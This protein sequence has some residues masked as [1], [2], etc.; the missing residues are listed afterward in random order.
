MS[1]NKSP[2]ASTSGA[3]WQ[4]C[5][6]KQRT[7]RLSLD[8]PKPAAA[9]IVQRNLAGVAH[10]QSGFFTP[11]RQSTTAVPDV[12]SAISINQS[13]ADARH[14][15]HGRE[16]MREGLRL[17]TTPA[18]GRRRPPRRGTANFAKWQRPSLA[19][20]DPSRRAMRRST[21]ASPLQLAP[22]ASPA[23]N[24][25]SQPRRPEPARI[26]QR[27]R[28]LAMRDIPPRSRD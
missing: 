22:S 13:G 21:S 10:H 24:R 19:G 17:A 20:E 27:K 12:Q 26:P 11:E 28:H 5:A 16:P 14:A 18:N 9:L 2:R 1:P 15:R 6:A 4:L 8:S 23:T 25:G 7:A 3:A